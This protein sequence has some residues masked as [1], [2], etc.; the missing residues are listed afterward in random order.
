M[1][2]IAEEN[3]KCM[4]SIISQA[5]E[6]YPPY[7]PYG[8][9][10][11]R[12]SGFARARR[13]KPYWR[14]NLKYFFG[15]S[16]EKL[17]GFDENFKE[18]YLTTC[19]HNNRFDVI[20]QHKFLTKISHL[21]DIRVFVIDITT[22]DYVSYGKLSPFRYSPFSPKIVKTRDF[23][24]SKL[25]YKNTKLYYGLEIPW[26]FLKRFETDS[27]GNRILPFA[28]EFW[29]TKKTKVWQYKVSQ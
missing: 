16:T 18:E 11:Y 7:G 1:D 2:Q 19:K 26:I 6:L 22:L 12:S 28:N 23:N 3:A 10:P 17:T 8:K 21:L 4:N 15:S 20:E 5:L 9:H 14:R 25:S 24:A 13:C 29:W 27:R